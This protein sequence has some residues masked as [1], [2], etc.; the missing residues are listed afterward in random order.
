[1]SL[2]VGNAGPNRNLFGQIAGGVVGGIAGLFTGGGVV[3]GA[4]AG[5]QIGNA[6]TGGTPRSTPPTGSTNMPGGVNVGGFTGFNFGPSTPGTPGPGTS[7]MCRPDQCSSAYGRGSHL[8]KHTLQPSK[9]HG[10]QP[11][12]TWC[13]R[14]RHM[15]FGNSRAAVR[16]IRRL[17][18][19]HR[20]FKKIDKLIG[21]HRSPRR[22]FGGKR[23]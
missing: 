22:A 12:G 18:G 21:H 17:K 23:R 6:L 20:I 10:L 8:N 13:V 4:T 1:M 11:P 19:A 9:K 3:A 7:V 15:N 14:T 2:V 5:A 16:S